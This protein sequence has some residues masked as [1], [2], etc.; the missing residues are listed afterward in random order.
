MSDRKPTLVLEHHFESPVRMEYADGASHS[1]TKGFT[2]RIEIFGGDIKSAYSYHTTAGR[3]G[4]YE[5]KY[6]ASFQGSWEIW[7][8]DSTNQEGC[9]GEGSLSFWVG[10]THTCHDYDGCYDLAHQVCDML[11]A[12]GYDMS[13]VDS[14]TQ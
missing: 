1:E 8:D 7:S 5:I 9:Y 4:G 11:T 2:V 13:E 12:V 3:D 6:P 10:S 14:R